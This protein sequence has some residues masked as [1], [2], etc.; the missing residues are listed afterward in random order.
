MHWTRN[1]SADVTHNRAWTRKI[2]GILNQE[3][4]PIGGCPDDEYET[5]AVMIAAMLLQ[6]ASDD[7]IMEYLEWAAV[8]NM[9]LAQF[10][11]DRARNAIAV[12]RRLAP[13]T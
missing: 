2:R 4:E 9:G 8:E 12:I 11:S 7:A 3:W 10:N 5:Y 1:F 6:D 13:G